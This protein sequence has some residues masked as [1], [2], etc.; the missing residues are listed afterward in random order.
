MNRKITVSLIAVVSLLGVIY[1]IMG[2]PVIFNKSIPEQVGYYKDSVIF[3][4]LQTFDFSLGNNLVCVYFAK[5]NIRELPKPMSNNKLFECNDNSVIEEL[6][7]N[8]EF[9]KSG[10]DMATCESRILVYKNDS[11]SIMNNPY[12][13][14][15]VPILPNKSLSICFKC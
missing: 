10:G 14:I 4:P 1:L 2:Y 7:D 8:F 3:N 15:T 13:T 11:L 6:R 12:F 5:D 9:V